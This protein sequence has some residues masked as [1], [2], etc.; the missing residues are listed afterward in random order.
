VGSNAH[1]KK[2]IF[3]AQRYASV[4]YA[5]VMRPSVTC[6]YYT[7]TA[8]HKIMQTTPYDRTGTKFSDAKN[9]CEIR[10]GHP[11]RGAP[12]GG[13]VGCRFRST[14]FGQYL[15]VSKETVQDRDI[16]TVEG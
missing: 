15:A 3:S 4:V 8:K 6:R 5:V 11:E 2:T 10:K 16:V 13:G 9:L 7:E 14:I 1:T 12:N